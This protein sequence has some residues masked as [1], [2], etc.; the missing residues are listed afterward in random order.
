[1][2]FTHCTKDEFMRRCKCKK[3]ICFGASRMPHEVVYELP[4]AD[5]ISCVLDNNAEKAGTQINLGGRDIPVYGLEWLHN[6]CLDDHVL[7]ITSRFFYD[8]F[9]QLKNNARLENIECYAWPL[10]YLEDESTP[11]KKYYNRVIRKSLEFYDIWLEAASLSCEE[12]NAQFEFYKSMVTGSTSRLNILPS[13]VLMHSNICSLNCEECCDLIPHVKKPYYLSPDEIMRDFENL[14]RGLDL[15]VK[16]DLTD[17]EVFLYPE[18]AEL[19]ER[20]AAQPKVKI[21]E[22]VTNGTIMP[23]EDVLRALENK[24]VMVV[25]SDYGFIDKLGTLIHCF[26]NR[27]IKFAVKSALK[28]WNFGFPSKRNMERNWLY[29]D[30]LRCENKLC[31]KPLLRGKLYGCMPAFRMADVG[32]FDSGKDYVTLGEDDADDEITRKIQS[33]CMMDYIEACGWCRFCDQSVPQVI[34]SG[35]ERSSYTIIKKDK[36]KYLVD[37]LP[38]REQGTFI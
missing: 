8:I 38:G 36:L 34:P 16:A 35:K 20:V 9:C 33:V 10:M 26:E 14:L 29:Y 28:W 6:Q 3:I 37:H 31:S 25:I 24:K 12:K 7:L 32:I 4:I 2:H 13:V 15:C 30:F 19:I 18:L 5:Q 11:E 1:M 23:S 21:V 27:G 17:G 22:M